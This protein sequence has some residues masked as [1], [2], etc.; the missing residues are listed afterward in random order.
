REDLLAV[1]L[2][3]R[4]ADARHGGQLREAAWLSGGDLLERR[5]VE[6]DVGG[7][8]VGLRALEP[9]GAERVESRRQILG[10]LPLAARRSRRRREPELGQEAAR[11]ALA[12]PAHVQVD[13]RACEA[14]VQE[15]PLLGDRVRA[16][17]ERRLA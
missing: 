11:L 5:V 12:R 4:R 3:L 9:P 17:G 8:L 16:A 13:A 10:E 2:D 15:A 7:H 1:A 14:D 6:D